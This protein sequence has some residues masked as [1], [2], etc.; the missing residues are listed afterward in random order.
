MYIPGMYESS[1]ERIKHNA[2]QLT[3]AIRKGYN[4]KLYFALKADNRGPQ[5]PELVMM[6]KVNECVKRIDG[7]KVTFRIIFNQIHDDATYN[8]YRD[9]L[10]YDN[11]KSLFDTLPGLQGFPS[12]SRSIMLHESALTN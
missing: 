11:F 1:N 8:M 4:H 7:S 6:A 5:D 10:A 9:E 2:S 3:E 12:T